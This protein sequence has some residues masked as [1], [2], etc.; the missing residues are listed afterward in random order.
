MRKVSLGFFLV[1]AL[2]IGAWSFTSSSAQAES[3]RV[4]GYAWSSNIGWISFSCRNL[5]SC[6]SSNYGVTLDRTSNTFS[7]YAWSSNIGWISFNSSDVSGCPTAPCA[8]GI[9][10]GVLHGWARVINSM[11]GGEGYEGWIHLSGPGYSATFDGERF[12]GFSWGNK[13]V[14]W[15][16]WNPSQGPGVYSSGLRL[17]TTGGTGGG[18][19]SSVTAES[20]TC[21]QDTCVFSYEDGTFISALVA[22][23]SAGYAFDHW[24]GANASE[25]PSPT[26]RVCSSL[27]MT[28]NLEIRAVFRT[29]AGNSPPPPGEAACNDCLD[30]D[31]DGKIDWLNDLGCNGDPYDTNE[32]DAVLAV[33][34]ANAPGASGKVISTPANIDCGFSCSHLYA[35]DEQVTLTALPLN[36]ATVFSTWGGACSGLS[37]SCVLSMTEARTVTAYFVAG[38]PPNCPTDGPGFCP[39]CNDGVDNDG[40]NQID[41]NGGNGRPADSSCESLLDDD[42]SSTQCP[43]AGPGLCPECNDGVDNDGDDDI[44]FPHDLQCDSTFDDNESGT[45]LNCPAA[46]PAGGCPQCN[47][48]VD[49]DGDGRVDY[50]ADLGCFNRQDNNERD[51]LIQGNCPADGPGLCPQCNDG[52]DNEGDGFVDWL[53]WDADHNGSREIPRDPSC[54]GDPNKNNEA[55]SIDVIEI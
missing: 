30:N 21:A 17:L 4:E 50:P 34:V 36:Q 18:S 5:N 29:D 44:D 41:Q 11:G 26:S 9:T 37:P 38:T 14:G 40:D 16:K 53:G 47:D 52:I 24:A 42:E 3:T 31:G 55:G 46:G 39:E 2:V 32:V 8:P 22:N 45:G 51:P 15:I 33:A 25:C 10:G 54:Q 48:G 49:N 23:P 7:G 20:D 43:A 13:V 27:S 19:S 1:C 28:S 35:N 12:A 6:G